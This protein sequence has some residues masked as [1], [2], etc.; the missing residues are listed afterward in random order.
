[1]IDVFLI[2]DRGMENQTEVDYE[3][4]E[5]EEIKVHHKVWRTFHRNIVNNARFYVSISLVLL[6]WTAYELNGIKHSLKD[7]N[8]INEDKD[9]KYIAVTEDNRVLTGVKQRITIRKVGPHIADILADYLTFSRYKIKHQ[10]ETLK[11]KDYS[12]FLEKQAN[13]KYSVSKFY[14]HFISVDKD[15]QKDPAKYK[16]MV[17]MTRT[18]KN[19]TEENLRNLEKKDMVTSFEVLE[20]KVTGANQDGK[21][22]IV[23]IEILGVTSGI[24]HKGYKYSGFKTKNTYTLRGYFNHDERDTINNPYG[25]KLKTMDYKL[26]TVNHSL[27]ANK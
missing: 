16:H 12:D 14:Q 2:K 23:A 11:F 20:T 18:L 9:S 17:N 25:I 5:Q 8:R 21:G 13:A 7:Y 6:A 24:T 1:M 10:A 19:F 15:G 27:G 22:F 3:D 4:I 26:A